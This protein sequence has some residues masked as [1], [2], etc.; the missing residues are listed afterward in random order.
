MSH[1]LKLRCLIAAGKVTYYKAKA[2]R[3]AA[4]SRQLKNNI[5]ES[6]QE[7]LSVSKSFL[8]DLHYA[9]AALKTFID[10]APA[11]NPL[12]WMANREIPVTDCL[13]YEMAADVLDEL[14]V[15]LGIT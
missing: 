15:L 14:G 13:E 1:A 9:V 10:Q 5:S 8:N 7:T 4:E 2:G 11:D 6:E 3:H 12:M